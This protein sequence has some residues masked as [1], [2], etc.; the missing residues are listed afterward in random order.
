MKNEKFDVWEWCGNTESNRD[1]Y[2][3]FWWIQK[4]KV[5]LKGWN[6]EIGMCGLLFV[7]GVFCVK[8]KN[9][10]EKRMKVHFT[11]FSS[12]FVFL[13]LCYIVFFSSIKWSIW[14]MSFFFNQLI[15]FS[16]SCTQKVPL[17]AKKPKKNK[18]FVYMR[19][20]KNHL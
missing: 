12:V 7:N 11:F 6:L 20:P 13:W 3:F 2:V 17:V 5:K 10:E 15:L 18:G 19:S 9:K 1:S 16:T 4:M 14:C 8:E